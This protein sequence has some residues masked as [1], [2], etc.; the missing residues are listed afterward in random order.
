MAFHIKCGPTGHGPE[1]TCSKEQKQKRED[2]VNTEA[3]EVSVYGL[4]YKLCS[5]SEWDHENEDEQKE[6]Q[7]F[8]YGSS[9][10]S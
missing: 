9:H 6:R 3:P 7:I 4:I 2:A 8:D 5:G 1:L 10:K